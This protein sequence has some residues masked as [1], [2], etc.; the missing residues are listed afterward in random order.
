MSY[1]AHCFKCKTKYDNEN[2]GLLF[3]DDDAH[4]WY[5]ASCSKLARKEI[6]GSKQSY[7]CEFCGEPTL[8]T[9]LISL[10][11]VVVHLGC[12]DIL[13]DKEGIDE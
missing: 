4:I 7:T 1:Y 5:C 12:Y 10:D 13:N 6:L 8:Q 9:E 3:E 11:V 2:E